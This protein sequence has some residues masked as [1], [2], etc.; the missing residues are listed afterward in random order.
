[1][2]PVAIKNG[3]LTVVNTDPFFGDG[4]EG[5]VTISANTTL[6]SD[7]FADTLMVNPGITLK[8]AGF[9]IFC[10]N[11]FTNQGTI[12]FDGP[13]AGSTTGGVV[14]ASSVLDQG[15]S[16][17]NGTTTN[18]NNGG[19]STNA[20][21]YFPAITHPGGIGGA[22]AAG[23]G[24]AGG[25]GGTQS[26][27]LN[28]GFAYHGVLQQFTS[29]LANDTIMHVRGGTGGGAG[30]GD[31]TFLGGG[32]GGGAGVIQICARIFDN[33]LGVISAS[34]GIGGGGGGGTAAGGGGGGGGV[35]IVC[36]DQFLGSLS[37][38]TTGGVGGG[39]GGAGAAG[40]S[41]LIEVA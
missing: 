30:G 13:N 26:T 25:A 9:R 28:T 16:G 15:T 1:M 27:P 17:G 21:V 3:V 31:G 23:T 11:K 22:G 40:H 41:F 4:S 7:L 37:I 32:G 38:L 12:S 39:A 8:T 24:G 36:Y 5:P 20:L 2:L 6:V 29:V 34:G 18:G 35:V 10:K 33:S 14:P 19:A